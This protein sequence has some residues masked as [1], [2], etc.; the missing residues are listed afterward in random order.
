M[1]NVGV[2]YGILQAQGIN[3][4]GMSPKEAWDKVNELK[5][6]GVTKKVSSD[7]ETTKNTEDLKK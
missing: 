5:Q 1:A 7:L 4:S 2:A 6:K 3:T